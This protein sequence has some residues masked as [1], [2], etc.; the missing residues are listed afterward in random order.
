[1]NRRVIAVVVLAAVI[2]GLAVADRQIDRDPPP[3]RLLSGGAAFGGPV[4]APARALSSTWFC[5]IGTARP[6]G[7]A[8]GVVVV[9]NAGTR[10]VTGTVSIVPTEGE[11]RTVP[12]TVKP[13]SRATVRMQDLVQSAYAAAIVDLD[14]GEV[15]VE[16]SVSGPAGESVAPCASGA[17]DR[18]YFATGSTARE[19]TMLLAL[20]NPFPEDAIADLSFSTDQGRAVPASFQGIVV[21]GGKL[22]VVNVGDHVRRRAAVAA[23]VTARSGRLVVDRLQ[24]K[25]GG[26]PGVSLAL[27][28]PSVGE[29]WAFADGF[30]TDGITERFH[31]YNPTGTEAQVALELTLEEGAAEPFE[32]T[33]PP[34]DR[35][36]LVAN[37]EERIPK[38]AGHALRVEV[39]SGGPV[40]AERSVDGRAPAARIGTSDSVGARKAAARWVLAAGS[41]NASVDEWVVVQNASS[42]PVQVSV[43]AL[44]GGQRLGIEGLQGLDLPAG[45]RRAIRLGDHIQR[46]DLPLLI[47]A[48][49]PVFVERSMFRVGSPG[50]SLGPAVPLR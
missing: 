41:S 35:V 19:D 32:L 30:V 34:N 6:D 33:V 14:G 17:S 26:A 21:K 47:E 7:P 49:G 46:D 20:F 31:V 16:H 18:W 44:A 4:A 23:T 40:V 27:G 48:D 5:A 13:A 8:D 24:L 11:G 39:L 9:A 3:S 25:G 28:A 45:R 37:D 43:I 50:L 12:L 22:A 42:V 1:M 2:V 10:E 36:T 15:V 29:V 38:N